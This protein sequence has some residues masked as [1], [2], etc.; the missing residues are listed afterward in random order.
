M[1]NVVSILVVPD[2]DIRDCRICQLS[3][4]IDNDEQDELIQL[5]CCCKDDLALAHQHCAD[6]WFKI[7]GNKICEICN[8]IVSNLVVANETPSTTQGTMDVNPAAT[9]VATIHMSTATRGRGH[10][11]TYLN[12]HS[13]HDIGRGRRDI[14]FGLHI[15]NNQHKLHEHI[16]M[17]ELE[18]TSSELEEPYDM[19]I[20]LHK[21]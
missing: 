13:T 10:A 16:W 3:S 2:D 20:P 11:Y 7:K 17:V 4:L 6:T 1:K 21:Q 14:F 12:L 9:S 19:N 15:E 18:V 5:G 8:S